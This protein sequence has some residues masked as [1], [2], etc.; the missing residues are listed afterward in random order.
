MQEIRIRPGL[1]E[2]LRETRKITSEDAMARLIGVDRTTLWRVTSG[3]SPSAAF[4]AQFCTAFGLG[5][6]EAFVIV[7][8][9]AA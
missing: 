6:G 3:S 1:I 5:L 4:I 2:T 8:S 7:D 9:V